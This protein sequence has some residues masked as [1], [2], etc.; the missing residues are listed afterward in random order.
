MMC[1]HQ[2]FVSDHMMSIHQSFV[3]KCW[4]CGNSWVFKCKKIHYKR[5]QVYTTKTIF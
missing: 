1:I 3:G 2:S 4:S 5:N